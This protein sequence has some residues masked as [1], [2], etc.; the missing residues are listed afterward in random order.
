MHS[1]FL[2]HNC[3]YSSNQKYRSGSEPT[4]L[5]K[6]TDYVVIGSFFVQCFSFEQNGFKVVRINVIVLFRYLIR[7]SI[8]ELFILR[9]IDIGNSCGKVTFKFLRTS[10]FCKDM[11]GYLINITNVQFCNRH[12]HGQTIHPTEIFI[13]MNL[14]QMPCVIT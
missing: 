1:I 11:A 8:S 13:L 9:L 12:N 3:T 7:K 5:V 2:S 4:F 6:A 10:Q 14:L